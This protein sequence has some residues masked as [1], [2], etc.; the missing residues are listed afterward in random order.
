MA[1]FS[2]SRR[3]P[4]HGHSPAPN[5]AQDPLR[6]LG[7]DP[8]DTVGP[9]QNM[10]YSE[11]TSWDTPWKETQC[12]SLGEAVRGGRRCGGEGGRGLWRL[13]CPLLLDGGF[14]LCVSSAV[15]T[16]GWIHAQHVLRSGEKADGELLMLVNGTQAQTRARCAL[17]WEWG[18]RTLA[19][20]KLVAPR[21]TICRGVENSPAS[22]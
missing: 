16:T 9:G 2:Y 19:S 13:S 21:R 11:M 6:R 8:S 12:T 15:E 7:A 4:E 14:T 18:C 20:G 5:P 1:V 3:H 22:G 10:M 17:R